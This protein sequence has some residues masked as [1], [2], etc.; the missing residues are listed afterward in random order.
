MRVGYDLYGIAQWIY[1]LREFG[2]F[3]GLLANKKDN[4]PSDSDLMYELQMPDGFGSSAGYV[5]R[6]TGK[7]S[8]AKSMSRF[9]KFRISLSSA[10]LDFARSSMTLSLHRS[11]FDSTPT[12]A[13]FDAI[14]ES[15]N[16]N[17]KPQ[18][19]I[20]NEGD[21][22]GVYGGFSSSGLPQTGQQK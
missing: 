7:R 19:H 17:S 15:S 9:L 13:F 8:K 6:F 5:A 4:Q 11:Q 22:F 21:P 16:P 20:S 14:L 1:C 2:D 3:P 18:E 12:T 10:D